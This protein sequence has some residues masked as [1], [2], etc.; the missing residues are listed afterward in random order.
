MKFLPLFLIVVMLSALHISA[1]TTPP[2][3]KVMWLHGRGEAG[4]TYWHRFAD[5]ILRGRKGESDVLWRFD[6]ITID[7]YDSGDD[8]SATANDLYSR[9]IST[10]AS[11]S[12][13]NRANNPI[14]IGHSQ[15]GIIARELDRRIVNGSIVNAAPM[16]GIITVGSP[17]YG[18]G[19]L[20]ARQRIT[21]GKNDI[22]YASEQVLADILPGPCLECARTFV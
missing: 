14:F 2:P 9:R 21:A 12:L 16:G 1:Q 4:Q 13:T 8:I 15:G 6:Y 18:V 20:A 7:G 11:L 19:L 17:N 22:Q 10:T 3:R 5:D